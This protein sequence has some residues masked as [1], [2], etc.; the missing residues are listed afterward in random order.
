MN[1]LDLLQACRQEHRKLLSE[2]RA[3][4]R[5]KGERWLYQDRGIEILPLDASGER[6]DDPDYICFEDGVEALQQAVEAAAATDG[7][8][9]VAL[10]GG[11]DAAQTKEDFEGCDYVPCTD[12]WELDDIPVEKIR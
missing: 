4:D 3:N 5:R 2:A 12:W 6:I 9:F 11:L 8:G 1:Y 7:A 10:G